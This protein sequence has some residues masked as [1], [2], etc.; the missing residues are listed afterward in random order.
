MSKTCIVFFLIFTRAS[1]ISS[2]IT[3]VS[4]NLTSLESNQLYIGYSKQ[5]IDPEDT[6]VPMGG[7]GN[8]RSRLS[9]DDQT[10]SISLHDTVIAILDNKKSGSVLITI[11]Q[12]SLSN[13]LQLELINP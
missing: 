11:D 12:V 8:S 1:S 7:Y 9:Q 6:K 10:F 5:N 13:N 3:H 2:E 4:E